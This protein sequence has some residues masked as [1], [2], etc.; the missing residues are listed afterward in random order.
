MEAAGR[1]D[2]RTRASLA[3]LEK[4]RKSVRQK[5]GAWP[6]FLGHFLAPR[7]WCMRGPRTH[8]PMNASNCENRNY[9]PATTSKSE[10]SFPRP[11]PPSARLIPALPAPGTALKCS[12]NSYLS[13]R[14][15]HPQHCY[16]ILDVHR[17]RLR[18]PNFRP[19]S[20]AIKRAL[21]N[22]LQTKAFCKGFV[23]HHINIPF[24]MCA[25]VN[26]YM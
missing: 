21:W 5:G 16:K 13:F 10:C 18:C 22:N 1:R 11:H 19:S 3:S 25:R 8:G 15:L 20:S 6:P 7:E 4:W 24:H 2:T 17:V 14:F 26:T 9:A 12:F 23:A